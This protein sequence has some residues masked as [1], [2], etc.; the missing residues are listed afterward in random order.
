LHDSLRSRIEAALARETTES[1]L[2]NQA[3]H[4]ETEAEKKSLH[5]SLR[6][7]IEAAL[8]REATRSSLGNQLQHVG[9]EA[10]KKKLAR[11]QPSA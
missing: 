1:A 10:E 3:Q 11:P 9:T 2:G 4:V 5:D 8:A 7:R 6:S